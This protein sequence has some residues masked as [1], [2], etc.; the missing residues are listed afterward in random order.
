[1]TVNRD[2]LERLLA[3]GQ[4]SAILRFSL[5]TAWLDEDPARAAIHFARATE[6]KEDYSAAWKMLGRAHAANG[7]PSLA[8]AAFERGIAV[9]TDNGDIQAQ[10]E[11][12][13]FLRRLDRDA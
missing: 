5:G 1:M 4:D 8:R 9:A 12:R 3:A 2:A 6:L 10:K 11:I 7:A 13:V